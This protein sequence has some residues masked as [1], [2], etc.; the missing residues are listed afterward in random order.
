MIKTRATAAQVLPAM[1]AVRLWMAPEGTE[2]ERDVGSEEVAC[3][4]RSELERG[5][6]GGK[7]YSGHPIVICYMCGCEGCSE[8]RS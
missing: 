6:Q 2:V 4:K 8:E 7:T 3:M 1:M 5:A